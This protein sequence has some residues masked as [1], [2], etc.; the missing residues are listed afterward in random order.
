MRRVWDG[1]TGGRSA[2]LALACALLGATGASAAQVG[3]AVDVNSTC[4]ANVYRQPAVASGTSYVV[5]TDGTLTNMSTRAYDSSSTGTIQLAV[6]RATATPSEY[7]IVGLSAPVT[8]P[9]SAPVADV[10]T[11]I[12]PIPVLAGDVLGV[13]VSNPGGNATVSCGAFTDNDDDRYTFYDGTVIVGQ[14]I[15]MSPITGARVSIAANLSTFVPCDAALD[16]HG[17][18]HF[19]EPPGS[20]TALDSSPFFNH[21]AYLGNPALGAPG[22]RGTA[23]T[24][25][26]VND[27]VRVPDSSSL[28]LGD[29]FTLEGWIRRDPTTKS[30]ELFN[31]G[32][33]GYQLV[34]MGSPN[35][36]QVFLRKAGVT[37]IVRSATGVPSDGAYHHVVATKNGPNTAQIYIDGVAGTV[38][39]SGVQ[40]VQDTAFPLT[41]GA[42]GSTPAQYDEFVVYDRALSPT[43][44]QGRYLNGIPIAF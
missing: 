1:R 41:F 38:N 9:T 8:P 44:V 3:Q 28:D 11:P 35:G 2:L 18:W 20:T 26:G 12:T 15:T 29:S 5:P 17:C 24:M 36:N 19:D 4:S 14:T 7:T 10:T 34:V 31:K 23:V 33:S 39:V 27:T 6:F 13:Q 25:D 43:E 37:T 32:G 42:A 22:V 21:G 30:H 16:A 40:V